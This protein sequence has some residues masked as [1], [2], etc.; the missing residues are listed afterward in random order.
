MTTVTS[1]SRGQRKRHAVIPSVH[2]SV[3]GTSLPFCLHTACVSRLSSVRIVIVAESFL[4]RVNGVSGSVLRASRHLLSQGH[5]VEIIAPS[6]SPQ[7]TI[8]GVRVHATRSFT[9]P[10]MGIDVGYAMTSTIRDLLRR[11]KPDVL[12]LASPLIL[13]HQAMRAATMERIP[14]V[15][16]Y[17]TDIS[18]FA[19]HYRLTGMGGLA[20]AVLR[21]IHAEVDLTLAPSTASMEYLQSLGIDRVELWGRGVDAEQFNPRRRSPELRTN[22]LAPNPN[23]VLVGFVG[24]LAPEKR[25]EALRVVQTDPRIQLVVIGAQNYRRLCPMRTSPECSVAPTSD[26]PWHHSTFSLHRASVRPSVR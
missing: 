23:R 21:R 10:G 9:V 20:D 6:P 1:H 7:F 22:W 5:A 11:L 16:I 19:R 4:P 2:P 3:E 8:D 18:G 24:R 15:A 13:G 17:Q 26:E 14:T 25:V 12:H